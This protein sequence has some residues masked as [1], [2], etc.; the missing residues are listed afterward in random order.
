MNGADG[1][2]R[3][4]DGGRRGSEG[5]A[6]EPPRRRDRS[7]AED[8]TDD[9]GRQVRRL[10]LPP[11]KGCIDVQEERRVVE[12]VGIPATAVH[13]LPRTRHDRLLVGIQQVPEREAVLEPDEPQRRCAREDRHQRGPA[14]APLALR[15]A[16]GRAPDAK[17]AAGRHRRARRRLSRRR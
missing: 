2:G 8:D 5:A 13:Q 3:G 14:A 7:E 10:V 4:C 11:L 17:P 16:V 6:P 1:R 12:P 15:P 9:A